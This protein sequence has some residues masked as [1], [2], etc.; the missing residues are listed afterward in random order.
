GGYML[1]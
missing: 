1:G